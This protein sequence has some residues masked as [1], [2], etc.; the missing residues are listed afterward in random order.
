MLL[1]G[2]K[3]PMSVRSTALRSW[4]KAHNRSWLC[5]GVVARL[6]PPPAFRPSWNF[7]C[8]VPQQM[9]DFRQRPTYFQLFSL[10]S[11]HTITQ[12]LLPGDDLKQLC[13]QILLIGIQLFLKRVFFRIRKRLKRH[14]GF[15][16]DMNP[17]P[18]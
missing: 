14:V 4:S 11:D 18:S 5:G 12:A 16:W 10:L 15:V 8:S 17:C 6:Q 3:S 2:S 7:P 1:T 9:L 13:A